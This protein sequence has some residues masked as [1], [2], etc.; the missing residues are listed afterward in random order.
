MNMP[1]C[2]PCAARVR[3]EGLRTMALYAVVTL[4]AVGLPGV[5]ALAPLGPEPIVLAGG[6]AGAAVVVSIVAAL[7]LLPKVPVAPATARG[8]AVT[9]T[10]Y[11]DAGSVDLFLT[12][13]SFAERL[14]AANNAPLRRSNKLRFVELG[15]MFWAATLA[16]GM[17][18]AV[19]EAPAH[20]APTK[21][22]VAAKP[23]PA[24][25]ASIAHEPPSASP[26]PS[27]STSK[28]TA[29]SAGKG[30]NVAPKKAP[31]SKPSP[32]APTAPKKGNERR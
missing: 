20:G 31:A 27:A 25:G 5:A 13:A 14:A 18:V 19:A 1:Y 23:E 21:D 29:P 10:R 16:V 3:G 17:V 12:N 8:E 9:V 26:P 24:A 28:A 7:V 30:A 15:A 22:P 32:P 4:L 2:D 11:D 6:A